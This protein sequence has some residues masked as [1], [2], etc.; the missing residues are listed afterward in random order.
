M[1]NI[2]LTTLTTQELK[3]LIE[4]A[5]KTTIIEANLSESK[6][7]ILSVTEVCE[8][9]NIKRQTIYNLCSQRKIPFIKKMG[10][11]YFVKEDII[12]WLEEDSIK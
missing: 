1:E 11:L 7:D 6:E 8:Y 9:L 5:L 2:V 3:H 10:R 12:Y 4:E